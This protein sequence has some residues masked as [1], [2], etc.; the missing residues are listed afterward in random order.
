MPARD[1][2]PTRRAVATPIRFGASPVGPAGPVPG[3]G[4]HG[5]EV[6]R[7]LGYDE[8]AIRGLLG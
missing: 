3:L 1:G 2:E 7:E 8:A 4:E 6:L 5:E